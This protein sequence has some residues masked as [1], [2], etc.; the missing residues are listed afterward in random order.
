MENYSVYQLTLD[1]HLEEGIELGK[2]QNQLEV[3][4]AKKEE[5]R[6]KEQMEKAKFQADWERKEKFK[7]IEKARLAKKKLEAEKQLIERERLKVEMERLKVELEKQNA[8]KQL[9]AIGMAD[10][11]IAKIYNMPIDEVRKIV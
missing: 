4:R 6:A 3:D 1:E 7:A 9:R 5:E 8:I 11:D 10:K 2:L